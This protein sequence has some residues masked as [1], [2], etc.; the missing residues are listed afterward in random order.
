MLERQPPSLRL[1]GR[2]WQHQRLFFASEADAALEF[3]RQERV[4]E[5]LEEEKDARDGKLG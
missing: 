1:I 2:R 3:E 4:F 5:R